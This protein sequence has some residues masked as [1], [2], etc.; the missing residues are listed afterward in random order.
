MS[1]LLTLTHGI[2]KTLYNTITV[3]ILWVKIK[4]INIKGAITMSKN[5][6]LN[7]ETGKIEFHFSKPEYMALSDGLKKEIKSAYLF[8]GSAQAWV[9]RSINNH[10]SALRVAKKLGFTE[11][12][13]VGERLTYEKELQRKAEK[14]EHRAER[15]EEYAVN[16]ERKGE[17]LQKELNSMHGD[18][19][20]FTQPIISGHA[21]SQAFGRRREAIFDRYRK[22]FDEYRKSEYFRDKAITAEETANMKQ[23]KDK[24]YL[25]NRIKECNS[26]IKKI[27]ANIVYYEDIIY[28]KQNNIT[29]NNPMANERTIEQYEEYLEETLEKMEYEMDKLAFL[30]NKLD[31][32][33]GIQ[34]SKENIKPGY[35]VKIRG[36]WYEVLKA[37]KTTVEG[38]KISGGAAG[39]V[40]KHSYAEI[41]EIKVPENYTEIEKKINKLEN[42]YI[43]GDILTYTNVSGNRIIEAF[44]VIKTTEKSISIQ[45]IELDNNRKPVKDAFIEGSKAERKGIVKSKYSD[46]VGAYYND[47]QLHKYI[48]K[49][50]ITA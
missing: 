46:Y 48:D 29:I 15:Y 7:K 40:L 11:Q 37:N 14:A 25:D 47:W 28:K 44:Q 35:N 4:K 31:E 32:I 20:F 36:S 23:L 49:E 41:Q 34:Y 2:K 8:S 3:L 18:I 26:N 30:E 33:G 50:S 19:A 10:Y 22:G 24:T 27:E 42:P 21:G 17:Q 5:Y 43:T 9:S 1:R 38:K 13:T 45:Q 6:I 39:M 16:A 12:E